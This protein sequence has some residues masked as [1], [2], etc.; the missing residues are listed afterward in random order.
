MFT[1]FA[2]S[3]GWIYSRSDERGTWPTGICAPQLAGRRD[4]GE[5][6]LLDACDEVYGPLSDGSARRR[7]L[8]QDGLA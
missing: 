8:S 6:E 3:K 5:I 1:Y 4:I 2:T 7:L